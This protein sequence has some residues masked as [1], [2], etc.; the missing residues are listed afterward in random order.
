MLYYADLG[1]HLSGRGM[2]VVAVSADVG[3]GGDFS[4]VSEVRGPVR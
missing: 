1:R 2:K 3:G 4:R